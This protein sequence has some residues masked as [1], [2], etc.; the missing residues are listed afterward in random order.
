MGIS[1]AQ[2]ML[3]QLMGQLTGGGFAQQAASQLGSMGAGKIKAKK[4]FQTPAGETQLQDA[5]LQRLLGMYGGGAGM[6]TGGQQDFLSAGTGMQKPPEIQLG[7]GMPQGRQLGPVPTGA[8]VLFSGPDP[9]GMQK[10]VQQMPGFGGRQMGPQEGEQQFFP[11]GEGGGIYT[12][13]QGEPQYRPFPGGAQ[14]VDEM[15]QQMWQQSQGQGN[16]A[17]MA[18]ANPWEQIGAGGGLPNLDPRTLGQL[19]A[20]FQPQM[21]QMNADFGQQKDQMLNDLFGRGMAQSTAATDAGG[22]LLTGRS[23]AM[24]QILGQ[25]AQAELGLRQQLMEQI[26]SKAA[27]GAFRGGGGMVP[28][29]AFG[30]TVD[31]ALTSSIMAQIEG[32][33]RPMNFEQ[34][35]AQEELKLKQAQLAQQG[36]LGGRELDI[37]QMLG[38]GSQGLQGQG[39]AQDL[40]M[41][42]FGLGAQR[43]QSQAGLASS[44]AARLQQF[45]QGQQSLIGGLGSQQAQMEAQKRSLLSQILGGLAGGASSLLGAAGSAGGFGALFGR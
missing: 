8:E 42:L 30:G 3:Q 35:M 36:S 23:T 19:G 43:Q 18:S 20:I 17:P 15:V 22:K 38:L 14:T 11:G 1:Q 28:P 27:A 44:E 12:A 7:F 4:M 41:Q 45:L 32:S 33:D 2:T 37:Q 9:S 39:L 10:G 34:R 5:V 25:K 13:P 29:N 21:D 24:N 6:G 16:P 40:M 31:G 26:G